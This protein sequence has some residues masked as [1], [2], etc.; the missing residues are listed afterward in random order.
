MSP[1]FKRISLQVV[2]D[3]LPVVAHEAPS[4]QVA[5]ATSSCVSQAEDG[6][7]FPHFGEIY[8]VIQVLVDEPRTSGARHAVLQLSLGVRVRFQV[9]LVRSE[10]EFVL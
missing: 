10:L 6:I 4:D 2:K 9:V 8:V 1:I 3:G 7:L 5:M